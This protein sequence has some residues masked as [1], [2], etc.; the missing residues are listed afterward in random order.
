MPGL[1][2]A[3]VTVKGYIAALSE[4]DLGKAYR[5]LEQKDFAALEQLQAANRVLPLKAG[6]KVDVIEHTFLSQ[7]VKFRVVGTL[8]ELWAPA[9]AVK[10]IDSAPAPTAAPAAPVA[11][12][13]RSITG[14]AKIL[15]PVPPGMSDGTEN[16]KPRFLEPEKIP[17]RI[18]QIVSKVHGVVSSKVYLYKGRYG[19]I[20]T[21]SQ[22]TD[23]VT[24]Q[25][26]QTFQKQAESI[27]EKLKV[28]PEAITNVAFEAA[29]GKRICDY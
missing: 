9:E 16:E 6:L 24:P 27:W 3:D 29:D 4:E 8:L 25:Q 2:Q 14:V 28:G 13:G 7:N 1:C 21:V 15:G 26:R 20:Y 17:T 12:Q 10:E 23:E 22:N 11:P 18:R 19:V 5:L